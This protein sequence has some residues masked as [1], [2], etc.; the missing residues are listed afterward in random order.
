[1]HKVKCIHCGVTF[2][3]DKEPFVQVSPRRY[4]HTIC[5]KAEEDNRT[6]EE[7][8]KDA[9]LDYIKKLFKQDYVDPVVQKQIKVFKEEYNFSYTGILKA[10]TYF[11]EIK[12][13]SIEKANGRI[14]I[15][16][17]IYKEAYDYYYNLWQAQEKNKDK[18]ISMYIPKVEE[19][20]IKSPVR[21]PTLRPRFMFLEEDN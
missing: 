3:R 7:K 2:D 4:A 5:N 12:G 1:M 14:T 11:Y 15:V 8:D 9:L 21:K 18:D 17:Y 10:L 6:Q 13:N 20:K 19:I 16:T